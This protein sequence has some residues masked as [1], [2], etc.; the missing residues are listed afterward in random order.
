MEEIYYEW[1]HDVNDHIMDWYHQKIKDWEWFDEDHI[2]HLKEVRNSPKIFRK[3]A[4]Q[5]WAEYFSDK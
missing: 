5:Y 1:E 2:E 4:E 3:I